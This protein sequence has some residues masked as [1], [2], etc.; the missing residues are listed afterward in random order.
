MPEQAYEIIKD[1][2]DNI[3]SGKA[4]APGLFTF[5]ILFTIWAAQAPSPPS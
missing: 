1:F 3:I 2:T 5:G 4:E